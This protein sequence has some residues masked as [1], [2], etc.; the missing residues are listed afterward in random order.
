L[1]LFRQITA[2]FDQVEAGIVSSPSNSLML[3]IGLGQLPLSSLWNNPSAQL[4]AGHQHELSPQVLRTKVFF[5]LQQIRQSLD[6][7]FFQP[8]IA[9]DYYITPT[10]KGYPPG[11]RGYYADIIQRRGKES[12]SVACQAIA[13]LMKN[14]LTWRERWI[15]LRVGLGGGIFITKRNN[16][17]G[18][19]GSYCEA[20]DDSPFR[21]RF[22]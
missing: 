16:C 13:T 14:H 22:W 20:S 17:I 3:A 2:T 5:N 12:R 18:S 10:I 6:E 21:T 8:L 4:N 9:V 1:S 11:A 15:A 19:D 7:V